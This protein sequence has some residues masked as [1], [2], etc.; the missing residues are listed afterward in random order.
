MITR[1]SEARLPT[2]HGEFRVVIYRTGE[3]GGPGATAVGTGVEEHVAMVLGD[4]SGSEVLTRVHS[5]CFTGEV[6]GSL[7][8]DCR[9]QLDAALARIGTEGRG[10][11]VYLVQEGRGIGLGNKVRAYELQ[12]EGADTVDA[13][14]ALGFDADLR[15]YDLAAGILRDLGATSVKL[16]TN[17]PQKIAGLEKAGVVIASKESHWVEATQHSEGYLATKK[18]KLGHV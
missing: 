5:S 4:A 15:S 11:L 10:V 2:P 1:F 3:N 18:A 9:A 17:N 8:C 7:R 12:D 6:L 13:N 16:M 14:L